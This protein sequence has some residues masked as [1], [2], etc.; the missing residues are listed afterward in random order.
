MCLLR[1]LI[2]RR[3]FH[4]GHLR[5]GRWRIMLVPLSVARF[6]RPTISK[7]D[8]FAVVIGDYL[9]LTFDGHVDPW[10]TT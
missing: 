2:P 6:H 4:T 1:I 10:R 8:S 7:G 3:A 5:C 9:P